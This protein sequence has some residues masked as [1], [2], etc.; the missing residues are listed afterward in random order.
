MGKVSRTVQVWPHAGS[1]FQDCWCVSSVVQ[2]LGSSVGS[3]QVDE[4]TASLSATGRGSLD[5]RPSARSTVRAYLRSHKSSQPGDKP[6]EFLILGEQV[7]LDLQGF[8]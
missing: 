1:M 3:S 7:F 8:M 2:R 5:H 6:L 4:E